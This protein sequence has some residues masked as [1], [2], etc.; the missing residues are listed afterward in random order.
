MLATR[1]WRDWRPSAIFQ[2]CPERELTKP[3][4][5]LQSRALSVLSVQ[6][7]PISERNT[8]SANIPPRELAKWR[9]PFSRWLDS[10]CVRSPRCFGGVA[11][12]HIDFC[13]W[14]VQQGGKSCTRPQFELLLAEAGCL[15][16]DGLAN[17]L[18]LYADVHDTLYEQLER[19]AIQAESRAIR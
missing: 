2:E 13:E 12:L 1:R 11:C 15:L 5:P 19:L 18:M 9:E 14:E 7:L 10:A 8:P 3:P 17:G 4:E 16:A 6:S